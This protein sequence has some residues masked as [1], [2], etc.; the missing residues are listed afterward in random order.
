MP[1]RQKRDAGSG[2]R[3]GRRLPALLAACAVVAVV[4]ALATW[5]VVLRG[6]SDTPAGPPKAAIID[7]LSFN[8]PNPDFVRQTTSLLEQAGYLVDYYSGEQITIDFYRGLASHGYTMLV[9]RSHADRIQEEWHGELVDEVVLFTSEPYDKTKYVPDQ[10]TNRLVV[11]RYQ[12]DGPAYFG[13][14]PSFFDKTVGDFHGA[15]I[16]MMG[17]QGML[18][19]HTAEAFVG[20]GAK[21]YISWD[22]L[23][24][25]AHT[26]A[27]T[28]VLLQHLLLEGKSA[29]QAALLTMVD[30][31]PDPIFGSRLRVYPPGS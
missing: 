27:A 28:E 26:D 12:K 17:C 31:G 16:V 18:T 9:F 4:A 25:A 1:S 7:Q 5:L 3:G 15:T 13:I 2:T 14:A 20:L 21:T 24:T 8:S 11:A 6:G 30:V 22:E 10:A 19:T 23:V 29:T